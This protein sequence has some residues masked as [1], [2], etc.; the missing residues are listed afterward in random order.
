MVTV[1]QRV[2]IAQ[3]LKKCCYHSENPAKM[4]VLRSI[5]KTASALEIEKIGPNKSGRAQ[6][7][8][9]TYLRSTP[10]DPENLAADW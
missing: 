5:R 2:I 4:R 1:N 10:T 3:P 7:F 8:E 9:A 6:I